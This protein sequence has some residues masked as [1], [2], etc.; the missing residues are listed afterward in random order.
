MF[1]EADKLL[2]APQKFELAARQLNDDLPRVGVLDPIWQEATRRVLSAANNRPAEEL[3][4]HRD[5]LGDDRC[6]LDIDIERVDC[7]GQDT[8]VL[9]HVTIDRHA[10]GLLP[11]GF[12]RALAAIFLRDAL[13]VPIVDSDRLK[14]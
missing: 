2:S 6:V 5:D 1:S 10:D 12:A 7:S 13:M 4:G 3:L 9:R 8:R 14:L 11:F